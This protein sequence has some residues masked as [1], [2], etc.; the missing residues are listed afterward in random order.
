MARHT[1]RLLLPLLAVLPSGFAHEHALLLNSE[2]PNPAILGYIPVPL[3]VSHSNVPLVVEGSLPEYLNG[4]LYRGAP[5]YW[6]DGW[7]LDGLITLNAFHFSKGA[8][9]FT[10]QWNK[11]EAYNRTVAGTPPAASLPRA[12]IAGGIPHPANSSWPTGVAF[13]QVQ[14]QVLG[15]TGVS[16]VNSFDPET[17]APLEMPF[18]YSDDLGA[19]FLSPTHEQT[20]DG[21]VV[22]HLVAG[23]QAGSGSEPSYIVYEIQPGTRKREVIAKIEKPRE[24]SPL[25]GYPSFQHMPLVTKE[26]YIMLEAPCYYPTTVT[27]VGSVDWKGWRSNILAKGHLRLVS[28]RTGQSLIYPL[29]ESIFAIHHINAYHDEKSNSIVVDTIQLFPW[30]VPCAIAFK[31]TTLD[32]YA[33]SWKQTGQGLSMSKPVRLVAPLDKPGATIAPRSISNLTG[34]EFP[35]IRYD[36]L[37]GKPYRY[38]Y[39]CWVSSSKAPYYDAL[40]K[41]DVQT[42]SSK[43][44]RVPGHYP[45]EPIF[46]P[47]PGG[48]AEDDGVVMTDVRDTL[49]NQTYLLVLDARTMGQVARAG[50]TPHV[51]PHGYHGRYFDR[52]LNAP[53]SVPVWV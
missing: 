1:T 10:M 40:V 19:P 21:H 6:P 13:R 9:R 27:P 18:V 47:R 33:K 32:A 41:L 53:A 39:G 20:I 38:A 34:I 46:V 7:W 8:V 37:N 44:W 4:T 24:S 15:S 36:D 52:K 11:D 51:I 17:L 28:R 14:G 35:T 49:K 12:P 45:G 31:G 29:T 50:P 43:A 25:Q 42:G 5:G 2:D 23:M 22:H 3:N 16:N 26:F 30:F 48:E